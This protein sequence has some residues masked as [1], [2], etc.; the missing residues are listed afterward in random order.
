MAANSVTLS[1]RRASPTERSSA[2]KHIPPATSGSVGETISRNR[3]ASIRVGPAAPSRSRIGPSN[4]TVATP[5]TAE[6][7]RMTSRLD[8][9]MRRACA[10][11][12]APIWRD[13]TAPRPMVSPI[14]SEI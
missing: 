13:T 9:A 10:A 4:A 6:A 12:P 14:A 8:P 3:T 2:L 11:A 1:A 5:I 7:A